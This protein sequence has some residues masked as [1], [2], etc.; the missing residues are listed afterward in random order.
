MMYYGDEYGEYG[1][2]DPNNRVDWRGDSGKLSADES[3]TLA[4]LRK[5][6]TAR[7]DLVAMRRGAYVPV[8]D[9]SQDVLVFARQTS[10]GD[11]ALEA[12]SRLLTP[13]TVTASLPPSL[14]IK[15]GTVLHDHLGGPDVPV[16]GGTITV[17]LGAQSA[18]ILAP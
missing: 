10:A 17:T 15:D 16:S 18:A 2:V 6:G 5:V 8:Y 11:V 13:T 12:L 9:T 14:G 7:H 1:G 4:F 3:A